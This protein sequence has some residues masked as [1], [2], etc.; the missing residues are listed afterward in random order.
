MTIFGHEKKERKIISPFKKSKTEN[1]REKAELK[2]SPLKDFGKANF[3]V[4]FR[5]KSVVT[6]RHVFLQKLKKG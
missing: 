5:S 3:R 2:K 6:T 4:K 1:L